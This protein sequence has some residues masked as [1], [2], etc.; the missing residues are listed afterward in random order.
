MGDPLPTRPTDRVQGG[1]SSFL[2]RTFGENPTYPIQFGN[3]VTSTFYSS[4]RTAQGVL[5]A[6]RGDT[7]Q[8]LGLNN[9][10]AHHGR[11]SCGCLGDG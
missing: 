8:R 3:Q 10:R 5:K 6:V 7:L 4:P 2:I 11:G 1:G 9:T